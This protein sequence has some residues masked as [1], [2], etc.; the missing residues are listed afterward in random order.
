MILYK[1]THQLI[2]VI[3]VALFN[4]SGKVI[5]VNTAIFSQ[6]GGSVG[7]GLLSHQTLLT[8]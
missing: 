8:Q 3:Q 6:S 7:I 5:G 1:L 2:E 4:M